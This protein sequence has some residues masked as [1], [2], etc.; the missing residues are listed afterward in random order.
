MDDLKFGTR[1]KRGDWAP[2]AKLEIAPYWDRPF[3]LRKVAE[4]AAGIPVSLERLPY[5]DGAAYWFFV[6]PDVEAMKTLG[7]GWALWLYARERR[8]DLRLLWLFELFYY[9]K[10]KQETR[11]K[12]NA[13]VSRPI[14]PPTSSG[15]RARTSTTSCAASSSP[16]RCGPLVE[17]LMLW[18][19]ANGYVPW[20]SWADHPVYLAALVFVAPMIHEVHFFFIHRADPLGAALQLDPFGPPQLDQPVAVV[21]AVDASGRRACSITRWRSGTLSSRPTR[22]SRCS[23]CMSPASAR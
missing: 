6:V 19:F 5:G 18:C 1:N 11:F 15:S 3:N 13:Q 21:V 17:V 4:V 10:R 7:W 16:S 8:G 12:Y 20:L 23:S 2:S 14:S 22:S 9:V